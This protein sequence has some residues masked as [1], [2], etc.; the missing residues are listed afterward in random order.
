MQEIFDRWQAL[1]LFDNQSLTLTVNSQLL[2]A[3]LHEGQSN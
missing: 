2:P 3:N 1:N